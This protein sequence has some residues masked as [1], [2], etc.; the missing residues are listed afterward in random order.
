MEHIAKFNARIG[1]LIE[2]VEE[3]QKDL[4]EI[5]LESVK[6]IL[7]YTGLT[8]ITVMKGISSITNKSILDD[9]S[10]FY[11]GFVSWIKPSISDNP[12]EDKISDEDAN[13]IKHDSA[14][15]IYRIIRQVEMSVKELN[16]A[17]TKFADKINDCAIHIDEKDAEYVE[18]ALKG[19]KKSAKK[20]LAKIASYARRAVNEIKTLN[21]MMDYSRSNTHCGPYSDLDNEQMINK[22]LYEFDLAE[23]TALAKIDQD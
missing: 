4:S 9:L 11:A 15:Y 14:S 21:I 23:S 7:F 18:T 8:A 22:A 13:T 17:V 12:V 16:E 20:N 3:A 19:V 1:T 2:H 5:R 6:E 10:E